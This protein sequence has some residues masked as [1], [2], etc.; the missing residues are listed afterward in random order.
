MP[1]AGRAKAKA[2]TKAKAKSSAKVT[3][4]KPKTADELKSELRHWL[5]SHHFL[6]YAYCEAYLL[7]HFFALFVGKRCIKNIH[8]VSTYGKT[9]YVYVYM[10]I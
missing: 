4:E 8:F 10:Y 9:K 2:K 7:A 6:F 1:E 5:T 3:E